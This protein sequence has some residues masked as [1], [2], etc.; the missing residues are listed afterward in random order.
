VAINYIKT[1]TGLLCAAK[2]SLQGFYG[3]HKTILY[4]CLFLSKK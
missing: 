4:L 2:D 3:L 1:K